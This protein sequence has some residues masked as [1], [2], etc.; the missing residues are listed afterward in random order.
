M[1]NHFR[2]QKRTMRG[3]VIDFAAMSNNH[4][5]KPVIGVGDVRKNVRGDLLGPGGVVIKTQEQINSEL[6]ARKAKTATLAKQMNIKQDSPV[7][8]PDATPNTFEEPQ[9]PISNEM[10]IQ[11]D[12]GADYPTIQDLLT[13]G[14][15]PGKRKII[16]K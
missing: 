8:K 1:A 2:K 3:N 5:T 14:T 9:E 4:Q 6:S 15:I 7:I 13:T 16:E 10:D 11:K 12:R